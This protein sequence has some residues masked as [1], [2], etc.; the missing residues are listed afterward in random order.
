MADMR[1]ICDHCQK[2][3]T[4]KGPGTYLPPRCLLCRLRLVHFWTRFVWAGGT[5]W[6]GCSETGCVAMLRVSA[7]P[8]W[9]AAMN[10]RYP[11]SQAAAA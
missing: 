6:F 8:A 9:H 11:N 4:V 7:L 5:L 3:T 1:I 2:P 10:K